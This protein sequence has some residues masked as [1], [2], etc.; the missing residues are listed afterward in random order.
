MNE[1]D[2]HA[3]PALSHGRI[4]DLIKD[5]TLFHG[6]HIAHTIPPWEGSDETEIGSALHKLVLEGPEAYERDVAIWRG[7]MVDGAKKGEEPHHS[8]RRGT[9]AHKAFEEAN[10]GKTIISEPDND[11]IE[12]YATA[13]H[14]D[15]DSRALLFDAE[16]PTEHTLTWSIAVSAG[17]EIPC[18]CRL[19]KLCTDADV[20]V[21][22][23]TTQ[24]ATLDEHRRQAI[25]LGYHRKADWYKRGYLASTGRLARAFLFV[26]IRTVY[27]PVVWVWHFDGEVEAVAEIEIDLAIADYTT[28]M[29]SGDWSQVEQHNVR[30]LGIKP[31][32]IPEYVREE[33]ERR[34]TG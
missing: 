14:D 28:R 25:K 7:G 3:L 10:R 22:L 13:L 6:R 30:M 23:K 8:M 1:T 32:E 21:D 12:R 24:C 18:K 16:G 20:I 15:P 4:E 19:D 29:L 34:R 26:S 17:I 9:K 11:A 33:M 2:Y 5:P 27:T 31:Y